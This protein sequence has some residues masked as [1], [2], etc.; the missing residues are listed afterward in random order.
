MLEKIPV[1]LDDATCK[2][3]ILAILGMRHIDIHKNNPYIGK[4][5][6]VQGLTMKIKLD[7]VTLSIFKT[8]HAY[9]HFSSDDETLGRH[10]PSD[11]TNWNEMVLPQINKH[12]S[13]LFYQLKDFGFEDQGHPITLQIKLKMEGNEDDRKRIETKLNACMDKVNNALNAPS[14][15]K[16][17][18]FFKP[19]PDDLEKD[20]PQCNRLE[21]SH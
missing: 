14:A 21:C 5:S 4:Y 13:S 15:K 3:S 19:A 9:A 17:A 6:F 11:V 20:V 10:T 18:S 12:F 1:V 7:D 8:P 2:D 16:S